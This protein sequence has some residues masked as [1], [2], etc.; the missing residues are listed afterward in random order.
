VYLY[1]SHNKGH[2]VAQVAGVS[3][4]RPWFAPRALRK[5]VGFMLNEVALN[6]FFSKILLF[7][8]NIV[9]HLPYIHS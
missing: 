7:S 1:V 5:Y 4:R 8:V 9:S 2:S 3:P 6:R